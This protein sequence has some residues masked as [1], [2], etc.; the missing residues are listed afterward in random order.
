MKPY[1]AT[2]F[3]LLRERVVDDERTGGL[4]PA[5]INSG[6][7][8]RTVDVL[9]PLNRGGASRNHGPYL[10]FGEPGRSRIDAS[11]MLLQSRIV[12]L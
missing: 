2:L 1:E 7:S 10:I 11:P 3:G 9:S 8:V 4:I 12:M 6:P 5:S